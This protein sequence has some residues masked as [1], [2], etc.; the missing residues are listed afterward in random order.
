M[1][2]KKNDQAGDKYIL[3][4]EKPGHRDRLKALAEAEKRSLN[5]QILILLE[6]GEKAQYLA[7]TGVAVNH[8][9]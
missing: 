8:D 9:A 1:T 2:M 4:F 3:R 5:K 6:A 7:Q